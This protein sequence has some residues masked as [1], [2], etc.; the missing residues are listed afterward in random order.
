MS[1]LGEIML[2]ARKSLTLTLEAVA[3]KSGT[4]KGYLSGIENGKVAPPSPR[5][6]KK[7]ATSLK[8]KGDTFAMICDAEKLM[9]DLKKQQ[10]VVALLDR[11][12]GEL[13]KVVS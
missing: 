2:N 3:K 7:I 12:Y 6:A 13:A 5:M 8:F 1:R 10:E 4:S 9:P 11:L